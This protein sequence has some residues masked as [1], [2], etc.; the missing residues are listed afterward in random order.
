[1]DSQVVLKAVGVAG[2]AGAIIFL[3]MYGISKVMLEKIP[4]VSKVHAPSLLKWFLVVSL[5]L[6]LAALSAWYYAGRQH[7]SI[8]G[9]AG[10]I[11]IDIPAST[12]LP[13]LNIDARVYNEPSR[14]DPLLLARV[15]NQAVKIYEQ[16]TSLQDANQKLGQIEADL[17]AWQFLYFEQGLP[18]SAEMLRD[19]SALRNYRVGVTAFNERWGARLQGTDSFDTVFN[20]I[21]V[22]Y[23]WVSVVDGLASVSPKGKL[24]LRR[25]GGEPVAFAGADVPAWCSGAKTWVERQIC[26][27]SGLATSELRV[28][29]DLNALRAK[30]GAAMDSD[31]SHW[32]KTVRDECKSIECLRLAYQARVQRF[33][34]LAQQQ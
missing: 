25:R 10:Q 3:T 32:R 27:D 17:A 20:R 26:G 6:G 11:R 9:R 24:I 30:F 28:L 2:S 23:G 34:E 21:L 14:S 13:P 16:A 31:Q 15:E 4:F 29:Q 5:G 8:D 18:Q 1:M 12:A 22:A 7:V 19:L 33:G